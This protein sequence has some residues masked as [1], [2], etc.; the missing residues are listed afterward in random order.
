M[1]PNT[2]DIKRNFVKNE[3]GR[4]VS[5]MFPQVRRLVYYISGCDGCRAD[6][7]LE[8]WISGGGIITLEVTDLDLP[9]IARAVL[10]SLCPCGLDC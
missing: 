1:N 2:Y 6:E 7:F 4:C 9:D 8:I 5:A 10:D 3:L